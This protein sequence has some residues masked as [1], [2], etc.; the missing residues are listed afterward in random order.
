MNEWIKQKEIN[1]QN[2]INITF[3]ILIGIF[4]KQTNLLN[5]EN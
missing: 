1:L 5:S 3:L 2:N 4:Q